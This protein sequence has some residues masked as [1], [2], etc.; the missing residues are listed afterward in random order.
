ML[1]QILLHCEKVELVT[2]NARRPAISVTE[3][4]EQIPALCRYKLVTRFPK[5][6]RRRA[7][8]APP[9][10]PPLSRWESSP[11]LVSRKT[12]LLA[13][14]RPTLRHYSSSASISDDGFYESN[15]APIQHCDAADHC[16]RIPTR[17]SSLGSNNA[18]AL[19]GG[20]EIPPKEK[21]DTRSVG[22]KK[23]QYNISAKVQA[24]P[25]SHRRKQN[26]SAAWAG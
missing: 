3:S 7:L 22:G 25:Q 19:G 23:P 11:K 14:F 15:Q 9:V 24:G 17:R 2:D 6:R 21:I 12:A 26:F 10:P 16:P 18:S 8:N 5:S 1:P 20:Q 4:S 13:E